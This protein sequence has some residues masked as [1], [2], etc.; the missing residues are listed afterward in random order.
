MPQGTGVAC[1]LRLR[2]RRQRDGVGFTVA[3]EELAH[4]WGGA[5]L[6]FHTAKQ[7]LR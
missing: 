1:D 7:M 5:A 6:G 2:N 3:P 4:W